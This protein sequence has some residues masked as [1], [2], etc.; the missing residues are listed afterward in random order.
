MPA[1]SSATPEQIK[2]AN[3]RYHDLAAGEYDAKWGIDLGEVGQA[4]VLGKLRKAVGELPPRGFGDGLEIGAGTGYFTLNM[5]QAGVVE[6]ATATDISDGMLEVLAASAAERGLTV[7]TVR[8]EAESLPFEDESFDLVFGHAVLHHIPDLERAFGEFSRVLRP[9]GVLAFC[10][11]PSRYG[12]R[13]AAVPKRVGRTLAPV[14]RRA[15]RAAPRNGGEHSHGGD[16]GLEW[17]VDVHSFSPGELRRL[18]A[19]AGLEGPRIRGEELAA[20][21]FGWVCRSLE[22]TAEPDDVPV[23]W[24][25]F[26]FRGYLALQRVDGSLLEPRLPPDLF[27]NLV[28]SARKP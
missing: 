27:Y 10:G 12:D 21:A 6:R 19:D 14:W 3:V 4:Q 24:R 16:H 5:L 18:I 23:A 11:E 20:N 26:A 15:L 17:H 2:D 1:A 13:I 25:T 9:G 7:E 8:T 28:L 22:S